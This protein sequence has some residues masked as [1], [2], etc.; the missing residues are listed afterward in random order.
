M[1]QKGSKNTL[2]WVIFRGSGD[3]VINSEILS[4]TKRDESHFVSL[5]ISLLIMFIFV[6]YVIYR[7]CTPK[8]D[9]TK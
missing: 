7:I 9:V 8:F 6:N 2:K 5:K 1:V 4:D 3:T